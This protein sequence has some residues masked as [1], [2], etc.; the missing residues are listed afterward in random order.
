MG[1]AKKPAHPGALSAK[2]YNNQFICSRK[3][4]SIIYLICGYRYKLGVNYTKKLI[5]RM[6][7]DDALA[8]NVGR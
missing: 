1:M 2:R 7:E 8:Q 4:N 5:S 6:A 3:G